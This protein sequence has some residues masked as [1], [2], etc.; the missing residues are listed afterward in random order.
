MFHTLSTH[1]VLHLSLGLFAKSTEF[2]PF[3]ADVAMAFTKIG[4][5]MSVVSRCVFLSYIN[6]CSLCSNISYNTSS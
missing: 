6:S 4:D 1:F 5:S 2:L 3:D